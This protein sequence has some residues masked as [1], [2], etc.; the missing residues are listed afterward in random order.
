MTLKQVADK[1]ENDAN[2]RDIEALT[3]GPIDPQ[4]KKPVTINVLTDPRRDCS[5]KDLKL[6]EKPDPSEKDNFWEFLDR[7]R[8]D[9]SQH[10]D[11]PEKYNIKYDLKKKT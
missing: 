5:L 3:F 7:D 8:P 10:K 6:L 4:A 9:D 11:Y 2:V 1:I